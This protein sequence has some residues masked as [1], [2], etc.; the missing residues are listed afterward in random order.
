MES[1]FTFSVNSVSFNT[2]CA[3]LS[4]DLPDHISVEFMVNGILHSVLRPATILTLIRL[5]AFHTV[6][7]I[8]IIEFICI[9]MLTSNKN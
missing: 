8:S 5:H 6:I 1:I 4:N 3:P 7:A 2:V 9:S